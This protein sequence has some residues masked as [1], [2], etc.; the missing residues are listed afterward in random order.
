SHSCD[1]D[2]SDEQ[3]LTETLGNEGS[4]E[5]GDVE[6]SEAGAG[7]NAPHLRDAQL[8]LIPAH[9]SG[10]AMYVDLHGHASKRGCFIYGNYFEDEDTQTVLLIIFDQVENMMFAK[11]VSLN[12]PHF[13]FTGCNFSERNMYTKDKRDGM[14]KEG[15]GRVAIYKATGLMRSYTLECNYNSGRAASYIPPAHGDGGCVTPPPPV[16]YPTKY[17]PAHFEDVGK[18]VAIATLDLTETNPWSRVL[19]WDHTNRQILSEAV[20]RYLRGLRGHCRTAKSS[21]HQVSSN[22]HASAPVVSQTRRASCGDCGPSAAITKGLKPVQEVSTKLYPR[23]KKHI[24]GPH[25]KRE[26]GPVQENNSTNIQS[27]PCRGQ[28][29]FTHRTQAMHLNNPPLTINMDAAGHLPSGQLVSTQTSLHRQATRLASMPDQSHRTRILRPQGS[30]NLQ[31]HRPGNLK[32]REWSASGRSPEGQTF[33]PPKQL[34]LV[35]QGKQ[36]SSWR[37]IT[38]TT[39]KSQIPVHVTTTGHNLAVSSRQRKTWSGPITTTRNRI[40]RRAHSDGVIDRAVT[41]NINLGII[42]QPPPTDRCDNLE[43]PIEKSSRL[44]C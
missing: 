8:Q 38:V 41:S 2:S 40:T 27:N 30:R 7:S 1:L 3:A 36:S 14:S 24:C 22:K 34:Q 21:S 9:A 31:P 28:P 43:Q 15:S 42:S 13:D 18:A 35:S 29:R 25:S 23:P 17:T 11:L 5:D 12:T 4:D 19:N 32:P 16:G 39:A 33:P 10:V 26:L 6:M 37:H 20:R 44:R